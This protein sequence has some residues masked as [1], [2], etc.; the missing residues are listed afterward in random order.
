MP[1]TLL[2]NKNSQGVVTLTLNRTDKHNAF[3]DTLI[4][5]LIEQLTDLAET[6]RLRVLVISGTGTSFSSGADLLWMKTMVNYSQEKNIQDALQLAELMR[7][8]YE[9]P[10]PTIARINGDAFGGALGLIA[11]CD[12][13]IAVN[14]AKFTF[15]EVRLGLAPAV[16]SPYVVAA[17]G[18][19]NTKRLFLTGERFSAENAYHL[20][21]IHYL[22]SAATLDDTVNQQI[23]LLLKGGPCAQTHC[24]QLVHHVAPLT[25]AT[26]LSTAKLIA[27]LRTSD[28][29]QEGLKAF[30]EKRKPSW[31]K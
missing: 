31:I 1:D 4:T 21:L 17:I 9:F 23:S 26:T 29:G 25:E 12:I 8:L 13:A 5:T 16:I 24:K 19:R 30:L 28:E 14:D 11:C 18:P 15:S 6:P 3:D 27:E 7:R 20:G 10:K 22:T 2:V